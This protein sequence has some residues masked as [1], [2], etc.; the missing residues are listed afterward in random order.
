MAYF[1][2]IK[3]TDINGNVVELTDVSP[4]LQDIHTELKA[5]RT[6]LNEMAGTDVSKEDVDDTD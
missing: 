2:A 6:I 1:A 5:I 3:V 4:L